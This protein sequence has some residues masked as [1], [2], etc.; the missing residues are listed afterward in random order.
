MIT[1]AV[2]SLCHYSHDYVT[3]HVCEFDLFVVGLIDT[4]RKRSIEMPTWAWA[5]FSKLFVVVNTECSVVL[6]LDDSY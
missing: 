2:M 6:S 1:S 3:I 4:D 5:A